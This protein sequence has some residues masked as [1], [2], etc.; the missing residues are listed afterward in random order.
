MAELESLKAIAALCL[1][2]HNVQHTV[3]EFGTFSVV[4][5]GPV[6]SSTSLSEN[7]VVWSEKLTE[8][9]GSN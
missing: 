8:W 5:L 6:V 3:D 4:T 1:L 2:A 7:E 9:S